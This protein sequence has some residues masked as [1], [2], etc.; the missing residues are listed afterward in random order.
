MATKQDI[1]ELESDYGDGEE[2]DDDRAFNI[3]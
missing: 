3:R 1:D 2:Y